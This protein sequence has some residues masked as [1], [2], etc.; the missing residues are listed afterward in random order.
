MRM[1]DSKQDH[2][3]KHAVI[4]TRVSSIKQ[5]QEGHGLESQKSRCAE[6]AR[7][8]GYEIAETFYDRG[9]SGS[10]IDRPGMK[11]MLSFLRKN[12]RKAHYVVLIDDISRLARDIRAHLDLKDAIFSAGAELESPG[13]EFGTDAN[14]IMFEQTQAVFAEYH[15]RRNAEQVISRMRAR[16][17]NGYWPFNPGLGYKYEKSPGQGKILV[18]DEPL[19]SIIQ[20][21][22]E[23][24]AS[25]Q[26]QIQAEVKRFFE[27]QPD[28]PKNKHGEVT[29]EQVAKILKRKLY[30]G[31]IEAPQWGVSLRR[32]NH[33][34]LISLET[35]ERIQSRLNEGARAPARKDIRD[36]FPLR[37][38]VLCGDCDRPMT[39]CYSK[40]RTGKKHP[41]YLCFAKGCES[42]RKSVPRT[43]MEDEFGALLEGVK[44]TQK[45]I[46]LVLA[47][48]KKG[49]ELQAAQTESVRQTSRQ[50]IGEID[51]Q[52]SGLLDRIVEA[53]NTRVVA[54]Y[55][56]KIDDLEK[57]KLILKEKLEVEAMEHRPF[58]EMFELAMRFLANPCILWNSDK[59][60][61]KRIALNLVFS[62]RLAYCRNEGF[63]TPVLALPFK[64]LGNV[65]GGNREL[66]SPE[67]FEP[68][69]Y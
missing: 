10:L 40:S 50:K 13:I 1:Q 5:T 2:T 19:A 32:G 21:A 69:T 14:G 7:F 58:N 18:R 25:G 35:Y 46:R 33:D 49:W 41:Y 61:H 39:S 26:F 53:T 20:Q 23:G 56:K 29:N 27:S 4:Y 47:M 34:A 24:F 31:Y 57:E 51:N 63:R 45:L 36:D 12:R 22:L 62:E 55:E 37:G 38:F 68:S 60:E 8:K 54:A 15:R 65:Y 66:V 52:V 28:F 44:P 59:F 43:Q 42:Y 64:A 6:F 17:M 9:V 16:L 67:G 11:E 3:K 30:A 48:F